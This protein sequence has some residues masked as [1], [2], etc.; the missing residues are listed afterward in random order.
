MNERAQRIAEVVKSAIELAP[1]DWKAFLDEECRSDE[2]MRAEI[3]SLLKHQKHVTRFIE[4]PALHLAAETFVRDSTH[5][6]GQIIGDYEVLSLIG[7]GGMG[8]VY[9]AQDRQL[10][11]RVALKLVRRGMDSEDI[12]RRFQREEFLLASLNH[13]NIAQLYGSGITAEGI[14]FFA[15]EYVEGIRIDQFCNEKRL[16]LRS[17]LELFRKICGAVHY[18]HQHL[19]VHRDIKPS[20]ILVTVEEEP[21]LLDF[22]IAKLLDPDPAL[23]FAQT[24]TEMKALTPEYASPEQLKGESVTTATDIYSLGVVLYELLTDQKPYRLKTQ[25]PDELSRAICEDEP[26]KPSTAL[27]KHPTPNLEHR[28]Q[29]LLLGDV[30]NIVLMAMRKEPTRRYASVAQFSSDI[31]RH[32]EG[33]PVIARQDTWS[34]RTSKAIR[35]HKVGVV[36]AALIALALLVGMATTSWQAYVAHRER[37]RAERRFNDVRK[38]ANSYLFEIHSAIENLP[39]ST[40]ARQLIIQ[41]AI[42]Y[43]DSLALEGGADLS[44]QREV[45]MAYLKAGNVQGN[46]RDANLGN[47]EG[48]LN[49]YRKALAIAKKWPVITGD[50][51]TRRPLALLYEKMADVEVETNQ[52]DRAAANARRSLDIFKELAAAHPDSA[53]E[54]RS[55][56]I[57]YL[58]TGD[59]LGNPNYANLGD[60]AGAMQNY[61]A[62]AK[63]L[64]SLRSTA[65]ADTRTRRFLG[66]IHER[67]G[68]VLEAQNNVPAALAEYKRSAEIRVPLAAEFPNDMPIVRDAAIAYE[69]LGNVMT[70][71]GDVGSALENRRK[72][73]EIFHRLLGADPQNTLAQHSL[74]VSHVHLADL[75]GEDPT[76]R[77]EAAEHYQDAIR[78]LEAINKADSANAATRRDLIEAEAKLG[79]LS[80]AR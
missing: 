58:K 36:A 26:A 55:V 4:E 72:S 68:A 47:T 25:R 38:L 2:A 66:M 64:E 41:R 21:K 19:V 65:V 57:S 6:A 53:D 44:L 24:I 13:P 63:I 59:V 17:R 67:I 18:A 34:Y 69:K 16:S 49:S 74:A 9:L 27:G 79:K 11:R 23:A 1:E 8:D 7:S 42:E 15:M 48:A 28:T 62:A 70:A 10:H 78:L 54:Q 22:G 80:K 51:G 43:L 39:G 71:T 52:L 35:R 45:V 12:V 75:L 73:L 60:Q 61:E 76:S 29:K 37:A 14:P 32:L 30:D 5:P 31:R 3:E 40:S 50:V 56:A 33:L 20:N 77:A 46:P